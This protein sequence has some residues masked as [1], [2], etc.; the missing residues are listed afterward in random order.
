[1]FLFSRQSI[2]ANALGHGDTGRR[3]REPPT[4]TLQSWPYCE[5][6]PLQAVGDDG[7]SRTTAD[8]QG[9]SRAAHN[10]GLK[11]WAIMR[12]RFAVNSTRRYWTFTS[13]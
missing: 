10:P 7:T 2:R 8:R 4:A 12:S 1:M 11:P 3:S 6:A 13:N 9:E 5:A